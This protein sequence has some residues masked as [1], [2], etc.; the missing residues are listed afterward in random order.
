MVAVEKIRKLLSTI[1]EAHVQAEN[2]VE[3]TDV[4]LTLRREEF[5][6]GE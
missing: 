1:P 5:A 2:V 6:S 4:N 3:N